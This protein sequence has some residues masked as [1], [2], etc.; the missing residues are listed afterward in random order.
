VQNGKQKRAQIVKENNEKCKVAEGKIL[1]LQLLNNE[2]ENA[3]K[4][5]Q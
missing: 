3:R 2:K 5:V 1:I 4:A